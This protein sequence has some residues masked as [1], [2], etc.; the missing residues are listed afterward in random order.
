MSACPSAFTNGASYNHGTNF[1]VDKSENPTTK[2]KYFTGYTSP[3]YVNGIS[4]YNNLNWSLGSGGYAT[5]VQVKIRLWK[6]A[7]GTG[8]VTYSTVEAIGPG[9]AENITK[10]Y[11]SV[12]AKVTGGGCSAQSSS[13]GVYIYQTLP[14]NST[15]QSRTGNSYTNREGWYCN[16]GSS[17]TRIDAYAICSN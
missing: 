17:Y 11:C 4:E 14:I 5:S 6:Q 15:T 10:A 3:C 9:S 7:N 13:S 12:G 2:I 1:F 8:G 16:S